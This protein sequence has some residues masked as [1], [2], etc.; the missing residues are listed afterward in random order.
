MPK[1]IPLIFDPQHH[2]T[3]GGTA[4]DVERTKLVFIWKKFDHCLVVAE[5]QKRLF[6]LK[7]LI[8]VPYTQHGFEALSGQRLLGTEPTQSIDVKLEPSLPLQF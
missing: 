4:G 3:S 5:H 1:V 8:L 2:H 7:T 6:V